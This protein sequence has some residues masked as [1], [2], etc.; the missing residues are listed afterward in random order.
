MSIPAGEVTQ[1]LLAW[2]E[3]DKEALARLVPLV[4]S[5]LKQIARR[6]M[7]RE[8]PDHT[9][10]PTALVNEAYLRLIEGNSVKWQSRAHFFGIA[11]NLMRQI[12]VDNARRHM[13]L[14]RG[15]DALRVSLTAAEALGDQKD[16]GI[17]ALDD[18]LNS[19]AEFDS[20][21]SKI[22]E[23]R[24]FGGLTEEE[25]AEALNMPLRTTQREWRL[26]RAWLFN[27]LKSKD[28]SES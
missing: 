8:R 23:L 26:A 14:K 19:L 13:Q 27:Q 2:G 25:T 1:L 16:A 18:A 10:Q 11:A 3:G 17:I 21:K 5:E 7:R 28:D 12:L 24:F 15:G 6:Y 22:I 9:L 20:R 4:Q